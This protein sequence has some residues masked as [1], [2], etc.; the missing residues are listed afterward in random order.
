MVFKNLQVD[1]P[2]KITDFKSKMVNFIAKLVN[3]RSKIDNLK[4]TQFVT[5]Y[6]RHKN[7]DLFL[8]RSLKNFKVN[9][10]TKMNDFTS[11]MA[12]FLAELVDLR[13]KI[14]NFKIEMADFEI[15]I[16]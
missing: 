2:R 14:D 15:K 4:V 9:F 7:E 5:I 1:F 16:T 6:F 12:I 3:F 10:P 11:K 13:M 8:K